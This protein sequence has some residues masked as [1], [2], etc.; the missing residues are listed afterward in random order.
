MERCF[1]KAVSSS[2]YKSHHAFYEIVHYDRLKTSNINRARLL[3]AKSYFDDAQIATQPPADYACPTMNDIS[4]RDYS[5][6]TNGERNEEI[7]MNKNDD[8][9]IPSCHPINRGLKIRKTDILRVFDKEKSLVPHPL[10]SYTARTVALAEEQSVE[11][12]LLD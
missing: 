11:S 4:I 1:Q 8:Y 7:S 9:H 2:C 12:L 10:C 5:R 3:N 6:F